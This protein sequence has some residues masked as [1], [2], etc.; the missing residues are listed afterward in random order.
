M[1]KSWAVMMCHRKSKKS[2]LAKVSH[3]NIGKQMKT[4]HGC[5]ENEWSFRGNSNQAARTP[6]QILGA[7]IMTNNYTETVPTQTLNK[8]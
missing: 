1:L 5:V 4:N 6:F 8:T 7:G 3:S 2:F